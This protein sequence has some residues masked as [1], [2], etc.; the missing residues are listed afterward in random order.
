MGEGSKC[1]TLL[2]RVADQVND[3][4]S[5]LQLHGRPKVTKDSDTSS[6]IEL[7]LSNLGKGSN[8]AVDLREL[9]LE[10][11]STVLRRTFCGPVWRQTFAYLCMRDA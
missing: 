6:R 8:T 7:D 5:M 11:S 1:H 4:S 2:L 3:Q 9:V 10:S